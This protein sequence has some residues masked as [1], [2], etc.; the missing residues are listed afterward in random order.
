MAAGLAGGVD[1]EVEAEEAD[2][3]AA[4]VV[5]ELDRG[6]AAALGD[7]DGGAWRAL[8][9]EPAIGDLIAGEEDVRGGAERGGPAGRADAG[10]DGAGGAMGLGEAFFGDFGG[11]DGDDEVGG[12]A[13]AGEGAQGGVGGEDHGAIGMGGEFRNRDIEGRT[14]AADEGGQAAQGPGPRIGQAVAEV[15]G[16]IGEQVLLPGEAIALAGEAG[17][18]GLL[19]SVVDEGDDGLVG[20]RIAAGADKER[21]KVTVIATEEALEESLRAGGAGGEALGGNGKAGGW[22]G[23]IRPPE[24]MLA[25]AEPGG[26]EAGG[27]ADED[28]GRGTGAEFFEQE[29]HAGR[30]RMRAGS[31]WISLD[32]E[33]GLRAKFLQGASTADIDQGREVTAKG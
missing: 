28:A 7:A 13:V 9:G 6:A 14:G 1:G 31:G 23:G 26:I 20:G 27:A 5:G 3:R 12:D 30:K 32:I 21:R 16:G 2:G 18:M 33:E 17:P 24:E 22:K 10:E 25:T 19:K 15:G 8:G 4:E 11:V 29:A